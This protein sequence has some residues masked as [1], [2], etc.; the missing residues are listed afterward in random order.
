MWTR[1]IRHTSDAFYIRNV[2]LENY[3]WIIWLTNFYASGLMPRPAKKRRH[4]SIYAHGNQ[5]MLE[6]NLMADL[7]AFDLEL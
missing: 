2:E 1:L 5:S 4:S 3:S 6:F 7:G